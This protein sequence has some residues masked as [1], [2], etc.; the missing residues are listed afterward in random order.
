MVGHPRACVCVGGGGRGNIFESHAYHSVAISN[1]LN[2]LDMRNY[3]NIVC[4]NSE[5]TIAYKFFCF[6][7]LW[8]A[9][10][11]A[12]LKPSS[13]ITHTRAVLAY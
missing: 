8:D 6:Y 9:N 11:S 10:L 1:I 3:H 12:M 7:S 13:H 5:F 2:V 4:C